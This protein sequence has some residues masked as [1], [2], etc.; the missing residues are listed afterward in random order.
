MLIF[1]IIMRLVLMLFFI[2]PRLGKLNYK[3]WI[4]F[5]NKHFTHHFKQ[6]E[7]I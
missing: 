7:L 2:P 3:E 6:F 5:H 1:E 4:I